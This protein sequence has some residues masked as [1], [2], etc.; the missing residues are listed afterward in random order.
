MVRLRY[1][2]LRF[3]LKSK[4]LFRANDFPPRVP[5]ASFIYSFDFYFGIFNTV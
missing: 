5:N 3:I 2:K 1:E 4:G